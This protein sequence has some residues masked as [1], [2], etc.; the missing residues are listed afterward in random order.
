MPL[1]QGLL[2]LLCTAAAAHAQSLAGP[3]GGGGIVTA[4]YLP[5]ACTTASLTCTFGNAS[6]ALHALPP[7]S[8]HCDT[9]SALAAGA[10]AVTE[11]STVLRNVELYGSA[12]L[13]GDVVRLTTTAQFRVI[14]TLITRPPL[15][16]SSAG[17]ASF[18]L[19]FEVLAGRG[20]GGEGIGVS[21]APLSNVYHADENGVAAGLV[22]TFDSAGDKLR[23]LMRGE[24]LAQ[25]R[26]DGVDPTRCDNLNC[27]NCAARTG[28]DLHAGCTWSPWQKLCHIDYEA[29]RSGRHDFRHDFR[30]ASYARVHIE[31]ADERLRVWHGGHLFIDRL[32]VSGW[33]A[34]ATSGEWMVIIGARNEMSIDDHFVRGLRMEHGASVGEAALTLAIGSTQAECTRNY[35]YYAAPAI[36]QIT[37]P[38]GPVR[39]GT[40][41]RVHGAHFHRGTGASSPGVRCMFGS[42][43]T[44]ATRDVA[45][46]PLVLECRS[47]PAV[48]DGAVA[49]EVSLNGL[50][51]TNSTTHSSS[52]SGGGGFTFTYTDGRV[53]TVTPNRTSSP[54][55]PLL[56]LGGAGLS[57]GSD[58]RCGFGLGGTVA[59]YVDAAGG[60]VYCT[61]PSLAALAKANVSA[62]ADG[63]LTLPVEVALNGVDYTSDNRTF[64]Y[65]PPPRPMALSPS[66]GPDAGATT[67]VISGHFANAGGWLCRFG[68]ETVQATHVLNETNLTDGGT[69]LC[70]SPRVEIAGALEMA[71]T[72]ASSHTFEPSE[73]RMYTPASGRA[74]PKYARA[75][76][77]HHPVLPGC[78]PF[79]AHP[80]PRAPIRLA[81][82]TRAATPSSPTACS[83]SP[84][85]PPASAAH[86]SSPHR[87]TVTTP[88]PMRTRRSSQPSIC[89]SAVCAAD[90]SA[91]PPTATAPR[92]VARA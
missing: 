1:R 32:H 91:P 77:L 45:T 55:G 37:Q 51:F 4:H 90:T 33:D 63:L 61:A 49:L 9:P 10:T 66:T 27:A 8:W 62:S 12:M 38:Q 31:L 34:L 74:T 30:R 35:T 68:G 82:T 71:P 64:T 43:T 89:A 85:T 86:A 42:V 48:Q 50:D 22:I 92:A 2:R 87:L 60:F 53:A 58:Y 5:A 36:S 59:A 78:P 52:S 73:L 57:G 47:P 41:V 54:N 14:G 7:S 72:L 29:V 84:T 17:A 26:L 16:H 11:W 76:S 83:C 88:S 69:L 70:T 65:H 39:G 20:T 21:L 25:V 80:R 79:R 28:C 44:P 19:S 6:T 40:R 3:A 56:I 24:V 18:A 75:I 23:V 15:S 46:Y 13:E 67:V 81:G